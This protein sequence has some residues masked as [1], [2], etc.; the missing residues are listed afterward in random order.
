MK[1]LIKKVFPEKFGP[2][3]KKIKNKGKLDNELVHISEVF[4]NSESYKFVSN[5]WHSLNII[6]YKN[7]LNSGTKNLATNTFGHYFNFFDY[8]NKY[9]KNLFKNINNN[10]I[11]N[12]KSNYIKKHENLDFKKS[13]NYNYL[14]LL[15]YSNLRK[16]KY[17]E[18]LSLLKDKTYLDFGNPYINI[19]NQNITSDKLISLFDLE[20]IDNF[21]FI[22]K[23]NILE[24]GAGSGRL[25]ECILATKN[26]LNFTV[27]DI[28]PSIYINYKR[29]KLAFPDKKIKLLIDVETSDELNSEIL[30]NDITFI[31]PHQIKKINKETYDMTIAVDCLHEMDKSTLKFYFKH[32]SNISKKFYFSIWEK[33]K[34][35]GSGGIFKK[36]ERLDFSK[37]DYPIPTNWTLQQK[38]NLIFPSNHI[39]LGYLLKK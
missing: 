4:I 18:L 3:F 14:L 25:S 36:T 20:S 1:K 7:I 27:C 10:E 32:I 38:K 5:Q 15:L 21:N 37:G 2:F 31:F 30:N 23:I 24:I 22:K 12:L 16:S 6:D 13:S 35:W 34:N 39:S 17:F 28:P 19:D 9:L 26:I 33:T 11:L 8:D 29:L